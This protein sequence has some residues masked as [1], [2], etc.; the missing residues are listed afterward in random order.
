MEKSELIGLEQ[1]INRLERQNRWWRLLGCSAAALLGFILLA[2]IGKPIP[3]ELRAQ[4]FVVVDST[5]QEFAYLNTTE[6]Q[7]SNSSGIP[8]TRLGALGGANGLRVHDGTGRL[9]IN[10]EADAVGERLQFVGVDLSHT[11]TL[12]PVTL[13]DTISRSLSF[14][15]GGGFNVQLVSSSIGQASCTT[16]TPTSFD[17]VERLLLVNP[18]GETAIL[19]A[20]PD[21]RMSLQKGE[22]K[23]CQTPDVN[24]PC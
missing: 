20:E 17:F 13:I 16:C 15:G 19:Q 18:G 24:S 8:I 9:Q 7:F 21:V 12:T 5:G 1:R 2:G 11:H 22:F 3:T 14:S 23:N 4:K 10:L 6:L